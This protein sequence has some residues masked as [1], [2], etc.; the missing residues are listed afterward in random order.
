MNTPEPKLDN[1]SVTTWAPAVAALG[2]LTILCL[3]SDTGGG[4]RASAQALQDS[5]ST[6]FGKPLQAQQISVINVPPQAMN[7]V[8]TQ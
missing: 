6:L 2:R 7:S 5:C 8:S 4:H 1:D 3:S